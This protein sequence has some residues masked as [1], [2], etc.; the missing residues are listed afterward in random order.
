MRQ[1]G[2][3]AGRLE[4]RKEVVNTERDTTRQTRS[5]SS[6]QAPPAAL[7]AHNQSL[8]ET[9]PFS[10]PQVLPGSIL[11]FAVYRTFYSS[12]LQVLKRLSHPHLQCIV[13]SGGWSLNAILGDGQRIKSPCFRSLEMV[14]PFSPASSACSATLNSNE[15]T[16]LWN[17]LFFS[18]S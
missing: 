15:L 14:S 3:I 7:T 13:L 8:V 10:Y 9:L 6:V 2:L 5:Q 11:W 4:A 12:E 17:H 18:L 1:H 16:G